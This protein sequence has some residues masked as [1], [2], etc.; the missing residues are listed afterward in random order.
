MVSR[1]RKVVLGIAL[2]LG[3]IVVALVFFVRHQIRKSFPAVDGTLELAGLS[4]PV[5][6]ERDDYGVP[7][8]VAGNDEDL[9]FALGFVHAQDRLWQMDFQRRTAAG[10]LA[11]IIGPEVL[12]FDRMMRL[13]GLRRS[14][15]ASLV[16]L[17]PETRQVLE[18][19]AA[20]V[21]ACIAAQAG[22]F[23]PEFDLLRYEPEPWTPLDCLLI[24]RLM[25]WEMGFSW[26][27]DLT[28]GALAETVGPE[29][30]LEIY[31]SYPRE[32]PPV[33]PSRIAGRASSTFSTL[34]RSA[35]AWFRFSGRT[36]PG[37]GSN[38]WA[39]RPSK[40]ATGHALLAN[41][42]HLFL[43]L[44]SPWYEV[45]L[46]TPRL[47]VSGMTIPGGPCVVAG[48]NDSIAWGI[49]SLMADDADFFVEEIN[50][51]DSSLYRFEGA[52]LPLRFSTEEIR[53]R[54]DSTQ[55]LVVR[56]TQH[57]PIVTDIEA[58]LKKARPPYQASIRW[59]G[60]E[61]HD[62]FAGLLAMNR[63]GNWDDFSRGVAMHSV[64]GLNFV[65]A[66]AAGNIGYRC[67]AMLPIRSGRSSLFPLPGWEKGSAWKGFI[68]R[69]QLPALL[70]PP[71][72][73]IASANNRITD[74]FYP[75]HISDLWEPPARFLRLREVLGKPAERFS[76]LDFELLQND[77]YSN[78]AR[79]I[80]PYIFAAFQD[81]A[82]AGAEERLLLD[83]LRNWNYYFAK[84]DIAT[85]I[86]QTFWVQL[87][88]NTYRDEMGDELFHD[89]QI[90]VNIPVRVTTA[91]LRGGTS[92]WFDDRSTP[93]AENRDDIVR[94]SLREAGAVIRERMGN[95]SKMWRWGSVHQV[96]L[97]HPFGLRAPFDRFFNL[98]PY[99]VGGASTAMVSFEYNLNEPFQVTVG[100]SFRQIFDLGD[101]TAWRSVISAGQSGQIFH[102]HFDDQTPLWLDGGY[103]VVRAGPGRPS[104]NVLRLVPRP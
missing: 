85:T 98:G 71:E 90:L 80:V 81:S 70:N 31:P 29:M 86:F 4:A 58:P 13:I 63:A 59:T 19:Y 27:T 54:G 7:A 67:G 62:P 8:L 96:T 30:V 61:D 41:D 21:N 45:Q 47:A 35:D 56:S 95:D 82:A 76:I 93:E 6:V 74:E 42:T 44:P 64:P 79:E 102:P 88:R 46:R 23:P 2:L 20:G 37:T 28:Y 97:T 33:V 1:K 51:L 40:S 14:A 48:R 49:T 43:M 78:N 39:V 52:W 12:P 18:H 15:E 75:Y 26:W 17:A 69:G 100:P 92:V 89:F 60:H 36:A 57:G 77:T 94:R 66:D 3:I 32:V 55:T 103:R 5:S 91:L 87:L 34:L 11:E 83:Y 38:A 101:P 50:P 22:R 9:F 104:A 10:R 53:I 65:Y 72:G 68:P 16:T 24:A 84:D 25:G 73:F 99:P